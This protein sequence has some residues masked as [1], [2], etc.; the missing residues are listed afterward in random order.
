MIKVRVIN[1]SGS[2]K[3]VILPESTT[4]RGAFAAADTDVGNG[5]VSVDC[6]RISVDEI[7]KPLSEFTTGDSV[8]LMALAKLQNAKA[9]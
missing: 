2:A 1:G 9:I 3:T 8:S 5:V 6:Q 7:D 4:I